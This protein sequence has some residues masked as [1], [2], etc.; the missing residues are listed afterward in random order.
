[1]NPAPPVMRNRWCSCMRVCD[2]KLLPR[3]LLRRVDPSYPMAIQATG[4][5]ELLS[6]RQFTVGLY[7][8]PVSQESII[9]S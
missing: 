8:P 2:K 1:M 7:N 4:E 3:G 5:R 9:F 6:V